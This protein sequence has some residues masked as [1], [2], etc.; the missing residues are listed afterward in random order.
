MILILF[1]L[2]IFVKGIQKRAFESHDGFMIG[3]DYYT[4]L[5]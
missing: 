4:A 1:K 5:G 2:K 3:I